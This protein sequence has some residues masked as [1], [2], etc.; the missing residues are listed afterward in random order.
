MGSMKD[1]SK[2]IKV[3]KQP[4]SKKKSFSPSRFSKKEYRSF[5]NKPI[6][7]HKPKN[8]IK[9]YKK[10][11]KMGNNPFIPKSDSPNDKKPDDV[12]IQPKQRVRNVKRVS[13]KKNSR[14]SKKSK[15]KEPPIEK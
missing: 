13:S 6:K 12:I 11:N 4:K 8:P 10:L 2:I 3:R 7:L 14:K 9:A 15:S 1:I 5:L